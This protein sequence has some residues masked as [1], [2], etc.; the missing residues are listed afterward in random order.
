MVRILTVEDRTGFW[1]VLTDDGTRYAIDHADV[2]LASLAHEYAKSG[3]LVTLDTVSGWHY[4][5]I[6]HIEKAAA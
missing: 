5:T 4:R 1:R 2:W 3:E 6:T